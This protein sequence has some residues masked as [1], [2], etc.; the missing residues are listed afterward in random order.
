MR[1]L[2]ANDGIGDAGGVQTYLD[3]VMPGLIARGHELAFLHYDRKS[4]SRISPGLARI[5]YFGIL[6]SGVEPAI[7]NAKAWGPHVCFSH[8]MNFLDV[9]R[10][11]LREWLVVKMMHGYFGT[12]IG[13]Q[14]MHAFPAPTPCDRRFSRTC[15]LHYLPRRCGQMNFGKMVEQYEW[16]KQQKS[17]F[18][19]Y[20]AVVV[21]SDHM[22]QEYLGNGISD[23][24]LCVAP[25]FA[26]DDATRDL[27]EESRSAERRVLF[28][29][30]M[31]KLK[32]GDILIR[33]VSEASQRARQKIHLVMAGD[34]PQ[35]AHWESLAQRLKV[36]ATFTGWVTGQEHDRL[37]REATLFAVP[38]VWPEPF[39]LVG[40]EAAIAGLPA[41]AF[42]V[43]GINQWLKDG[44]NG[45]LVPGNP[46]TAH[47]L[48][49]GLVEALSDPDRLNCMGRAARESSFDMSLEKHLDQLEEILVSACARKSD[50]SVSKQ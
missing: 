16:A 43:G 48:A 47:A 18:E 6:D 24:K 29:G 14:K 22:K 7:A 41:I 33:A 10:R 40:L 50:I 5:P 20:T 31:T 35:R 1:I 15:L 44:V 32:G 38:S 37:L 11:L 42:N 23:D 30:R 45:F 4:D 12:C 17:L 9:E 21:A 8:N 28:V 49:L 3:A 13:G 26:P 36:S 25:L 34:G 39:G 2:F 27:C 46:P 19:N